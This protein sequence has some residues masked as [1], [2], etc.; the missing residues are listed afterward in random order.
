MSQH[1]W[2]CGACQG[3]PQKEGSRYH[4]QLRFQAALQG[5]LCRS[6]SLYDVGKKFYHLRGH[7]GWRMRNLI[8]FLIF[9][10]DDVI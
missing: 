7:Q 3:V 5:D 4:R 10:N 9:G 1:G 8:N 2:N 6:A